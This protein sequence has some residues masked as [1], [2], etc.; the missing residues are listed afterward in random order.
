MTSDG[1][2]V[3]HTKR[4]FVVMIGAALDHS[5]LSFLAFVNGLF[6]LLST[7]LASSHAGIVPGKEDMVMS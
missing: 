4:A 5:E 2:K 6:L 3:F 7:S 1:G